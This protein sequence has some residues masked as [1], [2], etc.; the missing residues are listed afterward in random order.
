M[1]MDKECGGPF[2]RVF[3]QHVE[4]QVAWAQV[5]WLY[6]RAQWAR[7]RAMV[8]YHEQVTKMLWTDEILH[9]WQ[10]YLW[11]GILCHDA[12]ALD[13]VLHAYEHI[14]SGGVPYLH[15]LWEYFGAPQMTVLPDGSYIPPSRE[16]PTSQLRAEFEASMRGE[17][18]PILSRDD[19]E[20]RMNR[21]QPRE[22]EQSALNL[23]RAFGSVPT[24][25]P[26]VYSWDNGGA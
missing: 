8:D 7:H 23:P 21:I 4:Q 17:N 19:Y 3:E 14:R 22:T 5:P 24:I 6:L 18:A 1:R 13:T 15:R 9:G 16:T 25:P 12:A 20:Q 2:G 10:H 26:V 11:F